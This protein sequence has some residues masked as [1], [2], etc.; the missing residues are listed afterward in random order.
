MAELTTVIQNVSVEEGIPDSALIAEW[1]SAAYKKVGT[2]EAELTVRIVDEKDGRELNQRYRN[3]RGATNVLS[4][5]FEDPPQI[6]TNILG[7]IVVCAPVLSREAVNQ[8]RPLTAHWAHLV[9]HGVLHL[10]G[11][12]HDHERDAVR[13]QRLESEIIEQLGFPNPYKELDG[14]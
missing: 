3:K 7:D 11:Y 6:K 1:A 2:E 5:P 4:F 10:C 8:G 14:N 12:V 13:M 9:V